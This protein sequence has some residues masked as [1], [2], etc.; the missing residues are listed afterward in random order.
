MRVEGRQP[1]KMKLLLATFLMA[2]AAAAPAAASSVVMLKRAETQPSPSIIL[3]VEPGAQPAERAARP[4]LLGVA[5]LAYPQAAPSF[6]SAPAAERIERLSA[7]VIAM[8]TPAVEPTIVASI[9]AEEKRM[10]NPHLPPMVI[11]GGIFGNL[12]VNG[13]GLGQVTTEPAQQAAT[14]AGGD[15]PAPA[16]GEQRQPEAPRAPPPPAP[17]A[18]TRAPE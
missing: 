1:A 10:R 15:A 7:S 16:P 4:E 6:A 11:R 2:M 12:F 17:A 13:N 8:G 18:P 9:A 3:C 5:P 14:Q